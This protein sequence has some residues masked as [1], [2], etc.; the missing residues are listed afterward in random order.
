[1][2]K[3]NQMFERHQGHHVVDIDD[4]WNAN[5]DKYK[6]CCRKV[7]VVR[8]SLYI[9]YAQM[10]ITFVFA[11]FFG[12]RY[13]Q[14]ITGR[15]ALDHWMNQFGEPL[16]FSLLFAITLQMLV[17]LFLI[18]GIRTERR[19][20]LLPYIVLALMSAVLGSFQ[21][22]NKICFISTIII[23]SNF[24]A[25]LV[26]TMFQ[27]WC[28]LTIWRCY[29]FLG[30]KKVVQHIGDQL[31]TT[32]VPF[33]YDNIQ[34]EYNVMVQPPPYADTVISADKQPLTT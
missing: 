10:L 32:H 16:V 5:A 2:S 19:T 23:F 25:H 22:I 9:A 30:D 15:L 26:G 12:F 31:S 13:I 29:S 1:M 20:L 11:L 17:G 8:A 18:H 33:R 4:F 27:M 6:C 34:H 14:A 7:H 28:V 3:S 24:F 21:Y